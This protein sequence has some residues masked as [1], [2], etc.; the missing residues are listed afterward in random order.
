MENFLGRGNNTCDDP[1]T[2]LGLLVWCVQETASVQWNWRIMNEC[3]CRKR[4][5]K[6]KG[7]REEIF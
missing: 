3:A 5:K 7:E 2:C 1:V 6:K 4:S